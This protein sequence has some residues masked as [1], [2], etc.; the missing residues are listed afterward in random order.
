MFSLKQVRAMA[1]FMKAER[2]SCYSWSGPET[3][4]SRGF[5]NTVRTPSHAI[6]IS[7]APDCFGLNWFLNLDGGDVDVDCVA[8]SG[9]R[10]RSEDAHLDRFRSHHLP[11]SRSVDFGDWLVD[12]GAIVRQKHYKVRLTSFVS[13]SE[14][15]VRGKKVEWL[16]CGSD[17]TVFGLFQKVVS[18]TGAGYLENIVLQ[19]DVKRRGEWQEEIISVE[20]MLPG[21]MQAQVGPPFPEIGQ[22]PL[23]LFFFTDYKPTIRVLMQNWDIPKDDEV[24]PADL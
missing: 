8:G 5:P 14:L 20:K 17:E 2:F 23:S 6:G 15:E 11:R 21:Y 19:Y 24:R 7:L 12:W 9:R 1:K 10:C 13:G 22:R 18:V 4:R 3:P 16:V